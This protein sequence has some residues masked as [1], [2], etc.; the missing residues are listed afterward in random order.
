MPGT[1]LPNRIE[2]ARVLGFLFGVRFRIAGL[3]G[4]PELPHSETVPGTLG[5]AR[6][7]AKNGPLPPL[8]RL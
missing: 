6:G 8:G 2:R 5:R 3:L 1:Y 4:F 7:A